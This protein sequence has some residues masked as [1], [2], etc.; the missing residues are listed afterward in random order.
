KSLADSRLADGLGKLFLEY[1]WKKRDI[2]VY[3]SFDSMYTAFLIGPE[4]RSFQM[5]KDSALS[6]YYKGRQNLQYLLEGL[7]YQYDFVSYD[8]VSKGILKDYKTLIMPSVLSMSDAE[9]KAVNEF[10][11]SGGTVIAD[12]EPAGYDELACKRPAT[13]LEQV[14]VL[15]SVFDDKDS[16]MCN[17]IAMQ[18]AQ[19]ALKPIVTVD[20]PLPGREA[21]HFVDDDMHLFA[22]L[23]DPYIADDDAT[24]TITLPVKG[25]L[26][27]LRKR[28]YLGVTDTVTTQIPHNQAVV[29]GVYPYQ[30]KALRIKMPPKVQAGTD[31][32][33]ALEIVPSAGKAGKHVFHIEVRNPKGKANILMRRNKIA[34]NGKMDFAFRIA[35]NDVAGT[36]TLRVTDILSGIVTEQPFTVK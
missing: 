36:W 14:T 23:R 15:G 16:A 24:Q 6:N 1:K 10:I 17:A 27:D 9:V 20:A 26:Y 21:M 7:L 25:H 22:V 12:L 3:Y 29:F 35:H 8:Q 28:A 11:K 34:E 31:L 19:A 2:A 32:K 5:L 4:T 18:L 13:P 30:V 33:A